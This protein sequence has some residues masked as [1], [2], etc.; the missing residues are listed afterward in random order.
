MISLKEGKQRTVSEREI[1]NTH[2]GMAYE[3][4]KFQG[5][6]LNQPLKWVIGKQKAVYIGWEDTSWF[7]SLTAAWTTGCEVF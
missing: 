5:K 7:L 2:E 6:S 3:H 4:F 1:G